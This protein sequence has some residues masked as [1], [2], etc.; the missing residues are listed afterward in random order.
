M[1]NGKRKHKY[2]KYKRYGAV[3]KEAPLTR[4]CCK[5]KDAGYCWHFRCSC[6]DCKEY[7]TNP[8]YR[9]SSL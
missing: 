5:Y 2:G 8:D 9:K 4:E 6:F 1:W 3:T 7:K